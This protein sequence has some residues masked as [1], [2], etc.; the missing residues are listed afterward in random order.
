[1]LCSE[2][3]HTYV[4]PTPM[5]WEPMAASVCSLLHEVSRLKS[6]TCRH[7]PLLPQTLPAE[8]V[9][10]L[11]IQLLHVLLQASILQARQLGY[12]ESRTHQAMRSDSMTAGS[13][14]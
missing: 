2:H 4:H 13:A 9:A 3:A 1:M 7:L 12:A 8:V 10:H 5:A 14:C 11:P 6:I